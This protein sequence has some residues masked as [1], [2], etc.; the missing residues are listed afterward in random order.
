MPQSVQIQG[1]SHKA[2][3]SHKKLRKALLHGTVF[4]MDKLFTSLAM[5]LLAPTGALFVIVCPYRSSKQGRQLFSDLHSAKHQCYASCNS[6]PC[7]TILYI[8][9][10]IPFNTMQI[11][12]ILCI[13]EH[14]Y[15]LY[16]YWTNQAF[17][18]HSPTRYYLTTRLLTSLPYPPL[19]E[20]EKPLL[21]GA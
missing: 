15:I 3:K 14:T 8:H 19:P 4:Y 10:A 1:K 20:I 2:S 18:L 9:H 11:D 13:S 6:E 7:N 12:T 16:V 21:V 17:S 5:L